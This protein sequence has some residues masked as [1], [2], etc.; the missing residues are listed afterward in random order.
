MG[1]EEGMKDA[2]E[3]KVTVMENSASLLVGG[4]VIMEEEEEGLSVGSFVVLIMLSSSFFSLMRVGAAVE[5]SIEVGPKR[6]V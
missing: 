2:L 1:V 4:V 5:S 3:N 6:L